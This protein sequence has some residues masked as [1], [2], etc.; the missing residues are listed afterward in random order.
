MNVYA[1]ESVRLLSA[2]ILKR[3]ARLIWFSKFDRIIR[4]DTIYICLH[5]LHFRLF[6]FSRML[7]QVR[8]SLDEFRLALVSF[9]GIFLEDIVF[10]EVKHGRSAHH[11]QR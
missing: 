1:N 5:I 9:L 7:W 11:V 4:D 8:V 2:L 3:E 6:N 10:K